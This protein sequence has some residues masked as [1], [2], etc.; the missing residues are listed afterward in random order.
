MDVPDNLVRTVIKDRKGHIW[1]GSFGGGIF[2]YSSNGQRLKEFNT[3]L[4]FPSNTIN[5]LLKIQR[6]DMGCYRGRPST[7]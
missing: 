2:L 7:I 5:H 3:Y 1:I 4:G 6:T